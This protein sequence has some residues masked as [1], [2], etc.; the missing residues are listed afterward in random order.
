[1]CDMHFAEFQK[2]PRSQFCVFSDCQFACLLIVIVVVFAVHIGPTVG[3]NPK[4]TDPSN[5]PADLHKHI[6]GNRHNRNRNQAVAPQVPNRHSGPSVSPSVA[7]HGLEF[8]EQHSAFLASPPIVLPFS[9]ALH[10]SPY[11]GW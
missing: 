6:S 7:F 9:H 1:M 5:P 10:L 11:C 4:K 8:S 2:L 3:N